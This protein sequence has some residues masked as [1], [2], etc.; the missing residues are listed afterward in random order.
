M[1]STRMLQ[2]TFFTGVSA[3]ADPHTNK[4]RTRV[5][6]IWGNRRRQPNRSAMEGPLPEGTTLLIMVS[7]VPGKYAFASKSNHPLW[8]QF[9]TRTV[10]LTLQRQQIHWSNAPPSSSC[11]PVT[12]PPVKHLLLQCISRTAHMTLPKP[13]QLCT[14]DRTENTNSPSSKRIINVHQRGT[15][16]LSTL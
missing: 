16:H 12:C 8:S 3:N 5:T 15:T 2:L 1:G 4:L 13:W 6:H 10:P 9:Q 7:L 11:Q 14:I